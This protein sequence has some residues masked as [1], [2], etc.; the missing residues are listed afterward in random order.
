MV[1]EALCGF[2]ASLVKAEIH[3][4]HSSPS[5]CDREG[6]PRLLGCP[7]GEVCEVKGQHL[8]HGVL[9]LLHRLV[10]VAGGNT[11]TLVR[12]NIMHHICNILYRGVCPLL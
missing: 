9:I 12:E 4:L 3:N 11:E 5:S 6:S 10:W 1:F 7:E 8:L 2:R